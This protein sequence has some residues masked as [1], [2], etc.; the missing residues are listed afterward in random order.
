M[1]DSNPY[2][3][4]R[5]DGQQLAPPGVVGEL[6]VAGLGLARGYWNRPGLTGERFVACPFGSPGERMY[7][8]GDLV[9]WRA[10][11][12][13]V[14][15]GRVDD[16]V[17]VRGFRIELGEIETVV[18]RHGDVGQVVVVAREDRPGHKRLVAYVVPTADHSFQSALLREYLRQSLPE[19][20]VPSAFVVLDSLP[21]TPNGKL[22]RSALPAPEFIW[23]GDGM[24]PRTPQE[25]SMCE[26]FAE[27]LGLHQ[28]GVNDDFFDLGGH[29]LLATQLIVG[30]RATLG[31][32]LGLRALFETP[33]VAGL[34]ARPNMGNPDEAFDTMLPLR[35]Q[36]SRSPLFC[37][38]PGG[39][40][41]WSYRGLMRHLGPEYPLYAIQARSLARAESLPTS[42]EEMAADYVEQIRLV[43]PA[44][45]YFLLG[46][47][48]GGI[49]AHAV[50]T[51]L[52]Q[53]GQ[54]IALLTVLDSYPTVA[55][56][57]RATDHDERALISSLIGMF[58]CDPES[59]GDDAC[60]HAQ[61]VQVL[62]SR[63]STLASFEE[64]HIA[65][66]VEILINN[67]RLAPD[68]TPELFK[69]DLLMFNATTSRREVMPT[70]DLWRPYVQGKIE[71]HDI[72]ARHDLMTQAETLA[73]IGPILE[74][75]LQ[76]FWKQQTDTSP[77]DMKP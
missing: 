50:A 70:P 22:D 46:W 28:V 75:R 64:R 68:F 34:A 43:Q 40:I 35:S 15:V 16:Q 62:R 1:T 8:T 66:V 32:E 4:I 9:R 23:A 13:L 69:G 47:S 63:G 39:G 12:N 44:G 21:L 53:C 58:G 17:K 36:G 57:S 25:Q 61:I 54:Q 18:A 3:V 41:G 72:N 45:P 67:T 65:A 7:R 6:Y 59:L 76:A 29:S 42:V 73:Q 2:V 33:T 24:A 60:T 31:V 55:F 10:D 51:Q 14:F 56:S 71:S 52:Q 77:G 48:F 5:N 19:Y 26:L 20:M 37:I 30:V 11:G 38:H 74:A 49:V 27:V